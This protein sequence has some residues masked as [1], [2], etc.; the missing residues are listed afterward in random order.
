MFLLVLEEL[1][2]IVYGVGLG[3]LNLKVYKNFQ[4]LGQFC[5]M[6]ECCINGVA[7]VR[8]FYQTWKRQF[9]TG[10]R[11]NPRKIPQTGEKNLLRSPDSSTNRNKKGQVSVV[12]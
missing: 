6:D 12:R 8:D 5:L 2:N 11:I 1:N 10:S 3:F 4:E 9:F 7:Y